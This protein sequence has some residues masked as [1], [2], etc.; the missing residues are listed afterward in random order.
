MRSVALLLAA[1]AVAAVVSGCGSDK[2]VDSKLQALD[3]RLAAIEQRLDAAD[4]RLGALDP[5]P[6]QVAGLDRRLSTIE[7]G[8]RELAARPAATTST[9]LPGAAGG[10]AGVAPSLGTPRGPAAWNGPTREERQDRR[11]QLRA[12]SLEFRTKLAQIR[13]GFGSSPTPAD[14]QKILDLLQWQREQRRAILLGQGRTDQ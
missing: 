7:T 9:T 2:D 5:V 13:R 3:G 6:D 10:T 4:K 8:I 14:Q 11:D 1:G 12:L